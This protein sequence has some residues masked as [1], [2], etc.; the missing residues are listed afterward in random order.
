MTPVLYGL[1]RFCIRRRLIVIGV[2]VVAAVALVAISQQMGDNTNDNLS[3][4]GTNSQKA[5]DTLDRSFP[6]VA[7]GS[8]PIVF[9]APNRKKLTDSQ[10]SSPIGQAT[11]NLSKDQYVASAISPLTQQGAKQLNQVQTIGY[12]SVTLNT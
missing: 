1:A 9:K 3:L 2:W 11:S 8:N 10:Y 5:T 6:S 12:I 7:N 4:P